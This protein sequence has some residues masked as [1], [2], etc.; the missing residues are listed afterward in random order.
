MSLKQLIFSKSRAEFR[1]IWNKIFRTSDDELGWLLNPYNRD[2]NQ[3]TRLKNNGQTTY[4]HNYSDLAAGNVTIFNRRMRQIEHKK[5]RTMK[6]KFL[7]IARYMG[8]G[9]YMTSSAFPSPFLPSNDYSFADN[10]CELTKIW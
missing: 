2:I 1:I 9:A 7:K 5:T 8:T 10:R 3:M 4:Q 6:K